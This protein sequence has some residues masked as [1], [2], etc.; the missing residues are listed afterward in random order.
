MGRT[1]ENIFPNRENKIMWWTWQCASGDGGFCNLFTG[2]GEGGGRILFLGWNVW[3][4][5]WKCTTIVCRNYAT[6][7][8][9]FLLH[10]TPSAL[11]KLECF[12]G[13]VEA[14]G[15]ATVSAL[16]GNS[17]YISAEWEHEEGCAQSGAKITPSPA[18]LL[19]LNL[20]SQDEL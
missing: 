9:E 8:R 13:R 1:V 12:E 14:A 7:V 2:E 16:V 4:F 10:S 17:I 5:L 19:R 3:Q 18:F 20:E 11:L 15:L 6:C